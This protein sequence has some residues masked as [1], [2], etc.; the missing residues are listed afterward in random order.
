MPPTVLKD[1]GLAIDFGSRSTTR[2]TLRRNT[3]LP[4]SSNLCMQIRCA[5]DSFD[6]PKIGRGVRPVGIGIVARSE[7]RSSGWGDRTVA[8]REPRLRSNLGHPR[9]PTAHGVCLQ[10]WSSRLFGRP[11]LL[12]ILGRRVGE[13]WGVTFLLRRL[14][15]CRVAGPCAPVFKPV[16][17]SPPAPLPQGARGEIRGADLLCVAQEFP[18]A[19]LRTRP[20]RFGSAHH[21]RFAGG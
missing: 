12:W 13:N 6:A 4:R 10:L 18:I 5:P 15:L 2:F 16:N 21:R 19:E 7:C 17:P 3:S 9:R 11:N 14:S 1:L 20:L 8:S